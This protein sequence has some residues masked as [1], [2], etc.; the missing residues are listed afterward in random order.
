VLSYLGNGGSAGDGG[1]CWKSIGHCVDVYI[2]RAAV[3]TE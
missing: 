1:G 3:T 2:Y